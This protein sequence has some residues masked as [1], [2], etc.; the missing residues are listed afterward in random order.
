MRVR[1]R[2]DVSKPARRSKV[3]NLPSGEV[4][5]ILYDYER[6]QKRCY[7]CQRLT[8]EQDVCLRFAKKQLEKDGMV[9][10]KGEVLKHMDK[11]VLKES[12]PLFGVLEEN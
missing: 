1:V 9:D 6:L 7:T 8:H 10:K 3:V 11:L 4:S 5:T 2:F 12:D